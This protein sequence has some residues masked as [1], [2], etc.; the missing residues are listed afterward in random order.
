ML[1]FCNKY[2]AKYL[3][4]S[5]TEQCMAGRV[6]TYFPDG[7][8]MTMRISGGIDIGFCT[9]KRYFTN[10]ANGSSPGYGCLNGGGFCARLIQYDGWEIKD[11]YPW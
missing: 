8:V 2:L 5:K 6:C 10:D 4:T 1:D 7:T 11:D 9:D 3:V